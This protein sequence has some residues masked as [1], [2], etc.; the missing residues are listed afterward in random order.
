ML[1]AVGVDGGA[2][3][4]NVNCTNRVQPE[5]IKVKKENE[6]LP[7]TYTRAPGHHMQRMLNGMHANANTNAGVGVNVNSIYPVRRPEVVKKKKDLPGTRLPIMVCP[8]EGIEKEGCML[9]RPG[10]VLEKGEG[11]DGKAECNLLKVPPQDDDGDP[12]EWDEWKKYVDEDDL[13]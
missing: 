6:E 1:D 7:G 10:W 4:V 11:E 5:V 9:L 8:G 12:K 3:V 13:P 2:A